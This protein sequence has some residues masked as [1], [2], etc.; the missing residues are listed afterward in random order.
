M[1]G[2]IVGD[3]FITGGDM[4]VFECY[5]EG[6][7]D[8][9]IYDS[10]G[11]EKKGVGAFRVTNEET[12]AVTEED[13]E[14]ERDDEGQE[15]VTK[16]LDD[17]KEE[18]KDE[19]K[20]ND[21]VDNYILVSEKDDEGENEI[22]TS[23]VHAP[24]RKHGTSCDTREKQSRCRRVPDIYGEELFRTGLATHP[25][26][27][28]FV[29]KINPGRKGELYIPMDLIKVQNLNLP[30][31]I[32]LLDPYGRKWS[33]GLKQWRDGRTYYRGGWRR[34]CKMNLIRDDDICICEFIKRAE[35]LCLNI[36]FV[37]AN[38]D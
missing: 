19:D 23:N 26:N 35:R 27:P 37:R 21:N 15:G 38:R 28:Y 20:T 7:F 5:G 11:F 6:L 24:T 8:T 32:L 3:N 22:R 29:T 31:E 9:K 14:D 17:Q 16:D 36:S 13:G 1:V 18:G 10:S 34:L 33:A 25:K 2:K 30:K 12:K 4:L